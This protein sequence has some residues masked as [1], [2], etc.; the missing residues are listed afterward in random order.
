MNYILN[1]SNSIFNAYIL[2]YYIVFLGR[3]FW[4]QHLKPSFQ[5]LIVYACATVHDADTDLGVYTTIIYDCIRTYSCRG[6]YIQV[7]YKNP[8]MRW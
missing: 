1:V 5:L 3:W 2:S 4:F 8:F 7:I 6:R